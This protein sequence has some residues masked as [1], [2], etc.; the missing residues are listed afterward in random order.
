MQGMLMMWM[1]YLNMLARYIKQP[2]FPFAF[3]KFLYSHCHSNSQI[4]P[5]S[6]EE[7]VWFDGKI[8][9]FH[10]VIAQF[11]APS[12]LCGAG[13]MHHECICA[14]QLWYGEA[15]HNDTVF[16]SLDESQPGM[17][18]MLV[19]CVLLFFSFYDPYLKENIACALVNWFVPVEDEPDDVIGMWV[20]HPE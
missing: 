5:M 18:G 12:D 7:H 9:V 16:V 10:S 2:Q 4:T 3:Q 14:N 13:G 19:A 15:A 11:Y 6:L 1:M 17:Y 20:V 8:H